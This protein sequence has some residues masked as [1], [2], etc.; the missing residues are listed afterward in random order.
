MKSF[1]AVLAKTVR[2]Q[3]Y[4]QSL[5]KSEITPS[6]VIILD[7]RPEAT[8]IRPENRDTQKYGNARYDFGQASLSFQET[9]V[10]TLST[11]GIPFDIVSSHW[12]TIDSAILGSATIGSG[13][14]GSAT[15]E[16]QPL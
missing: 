4:I 7:E 14:I 12:A 5:V 3:A 1:I 8:K 9:L 2:S 11:A 6:Y 16:S 10:E 13:T 15:I